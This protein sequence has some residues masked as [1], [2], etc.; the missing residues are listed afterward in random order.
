MGD[1][2]KVTAPGKPYT[3]DKCDG[4]GRELDPRTDGVLL[5]TESDRIFCVRCALRNEGA[6]EDEIANPAFVEYV[7]CGIHERRPGNRLYIPD[8][9]PD[10]AVRHG[11]T[12][13][14]DTPTDSD[15]VR[16]PPTKVRNDTPG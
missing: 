1:E 3:V 12:P 5:H 2:I 16:R 14:D 11:E 15:G 13:L 8:A 9:F 7:T 6:T 10:I 4:C